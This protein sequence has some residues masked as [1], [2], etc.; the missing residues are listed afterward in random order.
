MI[1][2]HLSSKESEEEFTGIRK[3]KPEKDGLYTGWLCQANYSDGLKYFCN[4]SPLYCQVHP[5]TVL[6][7]NMNRIQWPQ[8][9]QTNPCLKDPGSKY[10]LK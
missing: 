9:L 8:T 2:L 6:S 3:Q 4:C 10:S 5:K 7:V 1:G